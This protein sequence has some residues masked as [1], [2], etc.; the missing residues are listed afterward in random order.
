MKIVI[1]MVLMSLLWR[2][3]RMGVWMNENSVV[4][5]GFWDDKSFALKSVRFDIREDSSSIAA[6]MAGKSGR[7]AKLLYIE[8]HNRRSIV[9]SVPP[10]SKHFDSIYSELMDNLHQARLGTSG[11]LKPIVVK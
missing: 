1:I 3:Q 7:T 4:V 2:Y 11:K 6:D 9:R 10:Y 8:D 5:C